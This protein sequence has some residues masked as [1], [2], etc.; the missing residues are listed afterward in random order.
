MGKPVI[1]SL[2]NV[3]KTYGSGA[4]AVHALRGASLQIRAGDFVAIR[5]A[6]GSGKST[7]MNLLGSLDP[8]TSGTYLLDGHDA[9]LMGRTKLARPPNRKPRVA[10]PGSH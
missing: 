2:D 5:G 10:F 4:A 3:T 7:L 1:L 9:G 6:S 8:P